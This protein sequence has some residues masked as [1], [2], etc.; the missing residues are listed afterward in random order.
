MGV[1]K[2]LSSPGSTLCRAEQGDSQCG[3]IWKVI[4]LKLSPTERWIPPKATHSLLISIQTSF[5]VTLPRGLADR[6][7]RVSV[8]AFIK[9]HLFLTRD[10]TA[11]HLRISEGRCLTHQL[12]STLRFFSGF[13]LYLRPHTPPLPTPTALRSEGEEGPCGWRTDNETLWSSV[14]EGKVGLMEGVWTSKPP[15]KGPVLHVCW[16]HHHH[17]HLL[18]SP[19]SFM[20]EAWDD[21]AWIPFPI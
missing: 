10:T 13:F 9:T 16:H 21:V 1:Q 18:G 3:V 7:Q 6:D 15:L 20:E 8:N 4:P 19:P 12:F 17:H 2:G 11:C 5:K 14:E